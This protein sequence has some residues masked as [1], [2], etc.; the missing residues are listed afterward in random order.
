MTT[1]S[2]CRIPSPADLARLKSKAPTRSAASARTTTAA[3]AIRPGRL[4]PQEIMRQLYQLGLRSSGMRPEARLVALTLMG[5]AHYRTGLCTKREPSSEE[6]A[7][8]TGLTEGQALVQLQILTSR[9][10]LT[11]REVLEGPRAGQ[12][13]YQLC[14]PR[15]ALDQLRARRTST[16]R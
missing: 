16:P 1:T 12:Q 15:L 14:I 9:G 7:Q 13:A 4:R 3:D 11:R 2:G 10:W 5:Y 8:A 6:L